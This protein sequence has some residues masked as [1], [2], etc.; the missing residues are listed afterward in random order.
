[1]TKILVVDDSAVD[2]RLAGSL[3]E[4][5]PQTSSAQATFGS[6]SSP[7]Q[8]AATA[9]TTSTTMK[10]PLPRSMARAYPLSPAV[11]SSTWGEVPETPEAARVGC[12]KPIRDTS[13]AITVTR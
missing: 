3:L 9:A 1:M 4:T 7:P 6:S 13:S 11:A 10:N 8:P 12:R 5:E 2:R